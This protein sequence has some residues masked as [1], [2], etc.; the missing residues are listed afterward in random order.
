MEI[1]KLRWAMDSS[2]WNLD[3]STPKILDGLVQLVLDDPFPPSLTRGAKLSKPKQ[4][5]LTQRYMGLTRGSMMPSHIHRV[6][7]LVI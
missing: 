1:N 7:Y 4:I 2:F 3:M 5:D 6:S